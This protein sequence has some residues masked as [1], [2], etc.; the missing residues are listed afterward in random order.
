M[1][2]FRIK[3]FDSKRYINK[4]RSYEL[5]GGAHPYSSSS[6]PSPRN[7]LSVE[8]LVERELKLLPSVEP[9]NREKKLLPSKESM[10]LSR[11]EAGGMVQEARRT[12]GFDQRS[13]RIL[14]LL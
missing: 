8:S 1:G 5:D 9:V 10:L 7:S 12:S 11:D 6:S 13:V 3:I 2:T 4:L 14:T